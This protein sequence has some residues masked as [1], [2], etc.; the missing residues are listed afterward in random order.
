[1]VIIDMNNKGDERHTFDMKD[2]VA[3][4]AAMTKFSEL[5][6]AGKFA[7][8]MDEKGNSVRQLRK[9]DPTAKKVVFR[10]QFIGG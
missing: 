10:P 5:L 7:A 9:F 8:E 6:G 1:M 3:V 2:A 4:E